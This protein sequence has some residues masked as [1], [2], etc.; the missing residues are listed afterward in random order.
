MM[1]VEAAAADKQADEVRGN[2]H[3][4][5]SDGSVS[6]LGEDA[7]PEVTEPT[8]AEEQAIPGPSG[9]PQAY[10][11]IVADWLTD[12]QRLAAPQL[13][14]LTKP[15]HVSMI[16]DS[17]QPLELQTTWRVQE[18]AW[19]RIRLAVPVAPPDAESITL[20]IAGQEMALV[21][22]SG[23]E[24]KVIWSLPDDRAI[25][26][27]KTK[28][29][30]QLVLPEGYW[31]IQRLLVSSRLQ[32]GM[33]IAA[34]LPSLTPAIA[35][36]P[37]AADLQSLGVAVVPLSGI[38]VA[39]DPSKD[40]EWYFSDPGRKIPEGFPGGLGERVFPSDDGGLMPQQNLVVPLDPPLDITDG[41]LVMSYHPGLSK[42]EIIADRPLHIHF[43]DAAGVT[44]IAQI[45]RD[46]ADSGWSVLTATMP[47]PGHVNLSEIV[48]VVL[49]DGEEARM[50]ANPFLLA[51]M[52]AVRGQRPTPA[53][54][55][56]HRRTFVGFD[57]S[58]V[59]AYL[60]RT[61]QRR[62]SSL[63]AFNPAEVRVLL[64]DSI[65]T[66]ER[67]LEQALPNAIGAMDPADT[68]YVANFYLNNKWLDEEFIDQHLDGTKRWQVLVLMTGGIEVEIAAM[69]RNWRVNSLIRTLNLDAI[70]AL[71][72]AG[73]LPVIALG[74]TK[75]KADFKPQALEYWDALA[76]ELDKIGVPYLDFRDIVVT[77]SSFAP[78]QRQMVIDRFIEG[79]VDLMHAL[80][81]VKR[82]QR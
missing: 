82:G 27:P 15:K 56:V 69:R 43:E 60:R 49:S 23:P 36:Q 73:I 67:P 34:D 35:S 18:D 51:K 72:K 2:E 30:V 46:E 13:G 81:A 65:Q 8:A 42:G 25:E 11:T 4:D 10:Q 37:S 1:T 39:T 71:Q 41:G 32:Q 74:P 3:A 29:P 50:S 44:G 55:G 33:K 45:E 79:Y 48:Q 19:F 64:G 58:K 78:G 14:I 6:F 9:P 57:V 20:R 68:S 22:W 61:M 76:K 47:N 80:E 24:S 5:R 70:Q 21:P 63:P 53:M 12:Q 40:S 75:I 77:G 17:Q 59:R 26:L 54:A 52:V 16:I 31:K 7:A 28:L 38:K 66:L 62:R